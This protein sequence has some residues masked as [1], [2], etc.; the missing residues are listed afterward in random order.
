MSATL[1][2]APPPRQAAV[3]GAGRARPRPETRDGTPAA[4]LRFAA[5]AALVVYGC[6]HWVRQLEPAPAGVAVQMAA[7]AVAVAVALG[8]AGRVGSVRRRRLAVGLLGTVGLLAAL[9]AAGIPLRFAGWRNWDKLIAGTGEGLSA[10][11]NLNVPYRGLD[12]WVRWTVLSG[13]ALLGVIAAALAFA[14]GAATR[15]GR[16]LGAALALSLLY[17]VPIVER[18]PA[19]PLLSGAGFAVLLALFVGA[20]RLAAVGGV[21][22]RSVA[23]GAGVAA[24]GLAAVLAP[25]LDGGAPW[26]DY[27]GLAGDLAERHQAAFDW[28]HSYAPLDWPRDGRELLRV[29]AKRPAYWKATVLRRFDGVRWVREQ[30]SAPEL[31]DTP[32]P[33]GEPGWYQD[34]EVTVRALRSPEYIAAGYTS[35]IT[36]VPRPAQAAG[37]GTY[38]TAGRPLR[39]GDTYKASVYTPRPSP[40]QLRAAGTV[41][42]DYVLRDL[43][44][45]LPERVGGPAVGPPAR[46]APGG[47]RQT[48]ILFPAFGTDALPTTFVPG[49]RP[50]LGGGELLARSGY[51]RTWAAAQRLR[52]QATSPFALVR[53]VRR[54]VQQGARY[55]ERPAQRPVPLEAFLFETREG[56]CQQFS[57]A[58]A[59]MLRM[60]GIPAR[61]ASGFTPGS[62]DSERGDYIVRD[63]D[64]HS[65]VE[66]FFPGIGWVTFDPTPTIAPPAAQD[67]GDGGETAPDSGSGGAGARGD[68]PVPSTSAPGGEARGGAGADAGSSPWAIA[69]GAL[70]LALAVGAFGLWRRPR[71]ALSPLEELRRAL[72]RSGRPAPPGLTLEALE[73]SLSGSSAAQGYVRKLRLARYAGREEAPSRAERAALRD[74]LA[75]G[76]GAGGRLRAWWAL[77]PRVSR[78]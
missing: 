49:R 6:E 43:A 21:R 42:P 48:T 75:G 74:H 60:A 23:F 36:Q 78:R 70:A 14:P 38:R 1:A 28:N 2:P 24:L 52:A 26:L 73:R 56:Y 54:R 71:T 10:L 45:E 19:S 39:P 20:D 66:A 32:R 76:L 68:V 34:I 31:V 35:D 50:Y 17:G 15:P 5:F 61:V 11:P 53:A 7:V 51:A 12:E 22:A 69:G 57:G 25:R 41:Y 8:L 37:S 62:F 29:K 13:A 47:P 9:T 33:A 72:A 55:A 58:M 65:W 59:L 3:A 16:R 77:P 67:T 46:S 63:L 64:A 30:A 44:I 27:R 4:G 18:N 40:Q